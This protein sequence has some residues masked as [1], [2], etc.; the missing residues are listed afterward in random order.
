MLDGIPGKAGSVYGGHAGS[1][2]EALKYLLF[3][4]FFCFCVLP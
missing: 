2:L 4:A 3:G 1:C